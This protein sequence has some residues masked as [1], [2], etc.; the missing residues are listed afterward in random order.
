MIIFNNVSI[1]FEASFRSKFDCKRAGRGGGRAS[2][3]WNLI[4]SRWTPCQSR[5]TLPTNANQWGIVQRAGRQRQD[6]QAL[7]QSGQCN[8]RFVL[9]SQAWCSVWSGAW[10]LPQVTGCTIDIYQGCGSGAGADTFWSEPEP[11]PSKLFARIRSQNRSR[12]R[13]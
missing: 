11:E 7:I 12:Q 9:R 3:L 2:H 10:T 13:L 1:I 8:G 4:G 6:K 5:Q